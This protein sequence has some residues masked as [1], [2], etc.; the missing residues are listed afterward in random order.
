MGGTITPPSKEQIISA[1][2]N[3]LYDLKQAAITIINAKTNKDKN[4]AI[5]EIKGL[6]YPTKNEEK[7]FWPA[8]AFE[9]MFGLR[10]K[11]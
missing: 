11:N 1:L 9:S 2:R 8:H 7:V 6:L 4:K 10:T 5:K 3:E